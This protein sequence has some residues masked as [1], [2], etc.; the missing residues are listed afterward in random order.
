[1]VIVSSM[2]DPKYEIFIKYAK[3]VKFIHFKCSFVFFSNVR[4]IITNQKNWKKKLSTTSR[5]CL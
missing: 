4:N 1:M 3:I 2:L 5:G